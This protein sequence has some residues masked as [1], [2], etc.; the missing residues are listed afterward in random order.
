MEHPER[1]T[2]RPR[3]GKNRASYSL[4]PFSPQGRREG[5]LPAWRKGDLPATRYDL[6]QRYELTPKGIAELWGNDR[7]RAES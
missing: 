6:T 5:D 2:D 3:R 1:R 4:L 7:T